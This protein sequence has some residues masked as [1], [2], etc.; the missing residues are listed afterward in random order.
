MDVLTQGILGGVLAQSVAKKEETKLATFV[1][2]FAGLIADADIFIASSSDPLLNIEF[3]R[4]FTHSIFFIPFGALIAT[5][6]LWPFLHKKLSNQRL[7]IFSLMGYSMSGFLDACTS[8]GTHLFWPLSAERISFNIISIIDPVFSVILIAALIYTLTRKSRRFAQVGLAMSFSYLLLGIVQ[9][10]R[11]LDVAEEVALSRGHQVSQQ[12]VKPTIANNL[13]W[14]SV[15]IADKRIYV[16]AIRL[17][18]FSDNKIFT[19]ES[20]AIFDVSQYLSK[21]EMSSVLFNDIQRFSRFSNG[22]I[23]IDK[24][25]PNVLGDIRYSMLPVSTKPLWGIVLDRNKLHEHVDYR[26]F[27]DNSQDIR[28]QFLDMLLLRK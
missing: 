27:R 23:A 14:R 7:Y 22:Y 25:Q 12:V 18:I 15:Y 4:H 21:N 10:Q 24:T 20:A 3:H 1:G 17:G 26:F 8:Y 5:L 6:I 19:G 13:L 9:H 11:A 2:V 28:T 16:D